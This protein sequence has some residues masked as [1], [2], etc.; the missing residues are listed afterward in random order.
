MHSLK[1]A[2][3]TSGQIDSRSRS[4]AK[5]GWRAP[6]R[7][8]RRTERQRQSCCSWIRHPLMHPS[9][10]QTLRSDS[11]TQEMYLDLNYAAERRA[12]VAFIVYSY[13]LHSRALHHSS[14]RLSCGPINIIRG[15]WLGRALT[16]INFSA[17]APD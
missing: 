13:S 17:P 16:Q 5:G 8:M 6:E 11:T 4:E 14:P 7:R 1:D 15:A 10:R 3:G 12:M 9:A 2:L